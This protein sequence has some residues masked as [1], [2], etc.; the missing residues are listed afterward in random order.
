M[1]RFDLHPAVSRKEPLSE[2]SPRN[3]WRHDRVRVGALHHI[4]TDQ[5]VVR[6]QAQ[7]EE[8]VLAML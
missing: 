6:K 5:K 4:H 7:R 1:E 2:S 8:Q 3:H